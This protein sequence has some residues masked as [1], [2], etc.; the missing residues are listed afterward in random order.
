MP[1]LTETHKFPDQARGLSCHLRQMLPIQ[2][3]KSY[4]S[5]AISP[6]STANVAPG[7]PTQLTVTPGLR[8]NTLAWNA[9]SPN[10]GTILTGYRLYYLVD[11]SPVLLATLGNVTHYLDYGLLAGE[12]RTYRITAINAKG[13]GNLSDPISS[14][15]LYPPA[16]PTGVSVT[17]D[18]TGVILTW[19]QSSS[20]DTSSAVVGYAIYRGTASGGEVLI[21]IV[22]ASAGT[23]VDTNTSSTQTYYYRVVALHSMTEAGDRSSMSVE[24]VQPGESSNPDMSLVI[25]GIFVGAM[26]LFLILFLVWKRKDKDKKKKKKEEKK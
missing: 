4:G 14:T 15:A 23:Y 21:D 10:G 26:V 17:R 7:A 25:G 24:I 18:D 9:P 16:A 3:K 11:G 6:V 12:S 19:V 13:E 8:N 2:S 20:N 5:A 1:L 22:S